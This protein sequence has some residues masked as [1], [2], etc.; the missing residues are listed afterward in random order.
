MRFETWTRAEANARLPEV[1]RHELHAWCG[2]LTDSERENQLLTV[3]LS[4]IDGAVMG[5]QLYQPTADP[6]QLTRS[7]RGRKATGLWSRFTWIAPK[8]RGVGLAERLW[9]QTL[10][11]MQPTY[12]EVQACSAAG[13]ALVRKLKEANP[14]LEWETNV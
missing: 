1:V 5:F 3:A 11:N 9:R 14:N 2:P 7:K 10:S 13:S 6:R 12:V 4:S 8:F